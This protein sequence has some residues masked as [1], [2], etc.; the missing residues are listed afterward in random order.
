MSGGRGGE[1]KP[2][3][4][5]YDPA[6]TSPYKN[7]EGYFL[8]HHHRRLLYFSLSALIYFFFAYE[9]CTG[10]PAHSSRTVYNIR[11]LESAA[12]SQPFSSPPSSSKNCGQDK[13][14]KDF[15]M[16]KSVLSR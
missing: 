7:R 12:A 3:A 10:S 6:S 8:L 1:T 15:Y 4:Q 16:K 14:K 11:F 13:K 9:A 5:L 2:L